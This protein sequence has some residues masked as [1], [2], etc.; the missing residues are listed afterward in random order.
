[1]KVYMTGLIYL[2]G[3]G[4]N[5][6]AF[7]P[8]AT[9]HHPSLWVDALSLNANAT[10]GWPD[11]QRITRTLD[12]VEFIEFQVPVPSVITFPGADEDTICVDIE[13]GLPKLKKRAKKT[14]DD[15]PDEPE[16]DFQVDPKA[17]EISAVVEMKGGTVRPRR[18]KDDSLVEWTTEPG[19][20]II[21]TPLG[22]NGDARTITVTSA[23]TEVLFSNMHDIPD[24]EG[25][26]D[27]LAGDH[28]SL[29][30]KLNA[31][32]NVDVYSVIAKVPGRAGQLT[33]NDLHAAALKYV[34]NG[35]CSCG[36]TPCC[37]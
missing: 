26:K 21:V 19:L 8:K 32:P 27:A 10:Q 36:R 34:A 35:G 22:N 4:G 37:C 23:A 31:E 17:R 1:M 24:E 6:R 3:C 12:G 2:T 30:K 15:D 5:V 33:G 9:G 16:Q 25:E 7:A 18:H 28:V 29:F 14:K 13:D 20:T 11:S